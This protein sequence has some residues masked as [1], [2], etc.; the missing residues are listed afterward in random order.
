MS[1]GTLFGERVE[2]LY[3][4]QHGE[5]VLSYCRLYGERV[6]RH[7][8]LDCS[9][10][11]LVPRRYVNIPTEARLRYFTVNMMRWILEFSVKERQKLERIIG[12]GTVGLIKIV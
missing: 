4:S 12:I 8:D 10:V 1:C 9:F 5:V 2:M 3:G 7:L 11:E 6:A